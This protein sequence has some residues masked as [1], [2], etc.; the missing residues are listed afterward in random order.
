M[1]FGEIRTLPSTGLHPVLL[2]ALTLALAARPLE[3]AAGRYELRGEDIFMNV[4]TF[5]TQFPDQKKAELHEQYID[6]QVL[7]TGEERILFGVTGSARQREDFH[8]EEDYRLCSEIAGEQCVTLRP[9]MCAVF[10]P[11]EPHKP[12]CAILEPG[13]IKKV[14]VK[15]RARLLDT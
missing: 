11:G 2:E 14:V 1:F 13:E 10:M 9:G 5:A 7:L 3:K 6:I 15:V 4:M 8:P 12:G